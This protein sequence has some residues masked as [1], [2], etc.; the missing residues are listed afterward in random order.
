MP[1]GPSGSMI[2]VRFG[3]RC[4]TIKVLPEHRGRGIGTALVETVHRRLG[5]IGVSEIE[6]SVIASNRE[7]VRVYE[8]LGLLP[9]LVSYIG[10][11]AGAP[12]PART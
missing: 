10:S 2:C 3:N 8:R 1:A 12:P 7:A 11:V 9:F 4:T 5:S 6:V